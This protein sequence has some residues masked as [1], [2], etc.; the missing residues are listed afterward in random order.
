[1]LKECWVAH[2]ISWHGGVPA[3]KMGRKQQKLCRGNHSQDCD[4]EILLFGCPIG[5]TSAI[6]KI[7]CWILPLL[8]IA[9]NNK[10]WIQKTQIQ[11]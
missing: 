11:T 3:K 7:C 6:K 2:R 8:H 9:E 1:M 4:E 10:W 5:T